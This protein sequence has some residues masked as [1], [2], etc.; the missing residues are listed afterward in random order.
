MA[1]R[2]WKRIEKGLPKGHTWRCKH[3]KKLGK[4]GRGIGGIVTRVKEEIEEEKE[5]ES[6]NEERDW[7]IKTS[8]LERGK[9]EHINDLYK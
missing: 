6:Q 4:T 3:P 9:V 7:M 8:Q 2:N 5:K 1:E